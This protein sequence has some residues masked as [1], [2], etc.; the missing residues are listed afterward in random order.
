MVFLL[1]LFLSVSSFEA[2]D[3][4]LST[5]IKSVLDLLLNALQMIIC[6]NYWKDK[7]FFT[8][9]KNTSMVVGVPKPFQYKP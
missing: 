6:K 3:K 2:P 9:T 4:N 1:Q 7:R 5:L 8:E